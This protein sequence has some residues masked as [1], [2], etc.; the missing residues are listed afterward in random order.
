MMTLRVQVR[1]DFRASRIKLDSFTPLFAHNKS[2]ISVFSCFIV[3]HSDERGRETHHAPEAIKTEPISSEDDEFPDRRN[4]HA[5]IERIS[6]EEVQEQRKRRD[7]EDNDIVRISEPEFRKRGIDRRG[8]SEKIEELNAPDSSD[9]SSSSSDSDSLSSSESEASDSDD[10]DYCMDQ[11]DHSASTELSSSSNDEG[12]DSEGKECSVKKRDTK[13]RSARR[14]VRT[15]GSSAR[16][17]STKGSGSK[18]EDVLKSSLDSSEMAPEKESNGDGDECVNEP[19]N[20]NS[21]TGSKTRE[22]QTWIDE[23]KRDEGQKVDEGKKEVDEA[24]RD[25]GKKFEVGDGSCFTQ[26]RVFDS[27]DVPSHEN[28]ESDEANFD[29]YKELLDSVLDSDGEGRSDG[30]S[31]KGEN[32]LPWRFRFEDEVPKPAEKT[33]HEL[34]IESLFAEMELF[35]KYEDVGFS[36]SYKE[37]NIYQNSIIFVFDARISFRIPHGTVL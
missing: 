8:H 5:W 36:S 33:E 16:D 37:V 34:F 15:N 2:K 3:E 25:E 13:T 31:N 35:L 7:A 23:A 12:Y 21:S 32:K 29:Q 6:E 4:R 14:V 11:S 26:R 1:P 27:N 22:K 20:V 24:K 30:E 10:E 19:K 18:R 9:G 17:S 28:E